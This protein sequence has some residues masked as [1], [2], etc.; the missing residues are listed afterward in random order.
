VRPHAVGTRV[1]GTD[2]E[3]VINALN[4]VHTEGVQV[5]GLKVRLLTISESVLEVVR[6]VIGEATDGAGFAHVPID[7]DVSVRHHDGRSTEVSGVLAAVLGGD[8]ELV[9][10]DAESASI[11]ALHFEE[12][13]SV[14]AGVY[15]LELLVVHVLSSDLRKIVRS[16]LLEI[17]NL[18]VAGRSG[19][20]DPDEVFRAGSDTDVLN[21]TA[22]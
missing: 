11:L 9:R 19:P 14:A 4:D 22:V 12:E 13:A 16:V 17:S 2:S 6:A 15:D 7:N 5:R 3:A 21:L 20:S 10:L 1:L 18:V 8:L